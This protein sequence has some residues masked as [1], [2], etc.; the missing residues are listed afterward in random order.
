MLTQVVQR[1]PDKTMKFTLV[2]GA[3]AYLAVSVHAAIDSHEITSLPGWDE[4][5]PSKMY[6]GFIKVRNYQK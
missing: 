5:L 6:S 3:F 2:A 4:D 1:S